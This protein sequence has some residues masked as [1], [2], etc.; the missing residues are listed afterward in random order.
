MGTFTR[1]LVGI[2]VVVMIIYFCALMFE[3]FLAEDIVTIKVVKLEKAISENGD[4]YFL[5][6]TKNEIFEN[7]DHYLHNKTNAR[8]IQSKLKTKGEYKIKVVGFNFGKKIPLFLEH[9]NIIEI[10][11]SKTFY[12]VTPKDN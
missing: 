10:I 2:I 8:E 7:T 4:K 5:I 12:K 1:I 11:E 9:R 3:R 6:H